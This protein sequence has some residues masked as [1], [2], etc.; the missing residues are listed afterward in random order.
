MTLAFRNHID[1]TLAVADQVI[2]GVDILPRTR[3]PLGRLFAGKPAETLLAALP[4]LFSL[5]ATAHQVALL[6]ALEAARGE[7]ATPLTR[8]RRINAVIT[9]RFA[10]LLRGL[11]LGPLA[12]DPG[13]LRLAPELLQAVASLQGYSGR[14][15]SRP[16]AETLSQIK[17]GL[18]AL[19][20]N[21]AMEFASPGTPLALVMGT[22]Q[23]AAEDGGWRHMPSPHGVL[24]AA[25]DRAVVS[26]LMDAGTVFAESPELDGRVPETGVWA[27]QPVRGSSLDAGPVERLSAKVAEIAA[28]LRWIEAGEAEDAAADRDVVA[29]YAL[30][31]GRGGAAVECARGRLHHVVELDAQGVIARFEYLAPTEWNFHPRGPVVRSLTG[32]ALR[33]PRDHDAI[34]TM[35][36]A[37]DPCVGYRLAVREMADA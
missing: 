35:V 19:G 37:F 27:R 24:S 17:M 15:A 1:I 21:F 10:E 33:C 6:S 12:G 34:R 8:H 22:V 26:R 28:L 36:G 20:I 29:S 30:G 11:L 2:T 14:P 4:R 32:A 16:R 7:Q 31:A 13:A 5:C 23:E 18:G 9:E 25:D 3:P